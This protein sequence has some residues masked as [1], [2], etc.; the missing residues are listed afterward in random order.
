MVRVKPVNNKSFNNHR[1]HYESV[2]LYNDNKEY[3]QLLVHRLVCQMFQPNPHCFKIVD[4]IDG[5]GKNNHFS[6]I[7]WVSNSQN[8]Y[9]RVMADPKYLNG[10]YKRENRYLVRKLDDSKYQ[11]FETYLEA[12]K[13]N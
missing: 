10:I 13:Y 7:R 11:S 6:N 8:M 3:K 5:N 9:N 12:A 2:Y 4:H 1:A